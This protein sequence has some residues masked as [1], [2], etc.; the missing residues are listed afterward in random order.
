MNEVL[1]YAA[2]ATLVCVMLYSV[3]GK[4]VGQG[5]ES[6]VDPLKFMENDQPETG[7]VAPV[8][9]D[10]GIPGLSEIM[11]ADRDFSPSGF[12]DGAQGAYSMILEAFAE[13]NRELLGELLTDN[14]Y[15]VYDEAITERE[16]QSLTQVTDLA[17]IKG[18]EIVNAQ[19]D[20]GLA[21]VSVRY[22]AELSSA[23]VDA[24][25]AA[26][27]GDPDLLSSVSEIWTFERSFKSKDPN[28][29]LSDVAP[30]DGDDFEADPTPDTKKPD[31]ETKA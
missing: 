10:Q 3:L 27:H 26:V 6:G 20:G 23:L 8:E 17:R 24:D 1:L 28:W 12:L 4:S 31:A 16:E 9:S 18:A 29:L 11:A 30:S 15:K 21:R 2:I 14:V 25:G 7:F 19:K 5:P 22:E 13:G